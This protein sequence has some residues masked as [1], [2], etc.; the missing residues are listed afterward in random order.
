MRSGSRAIE[1]CVPGMRS[2]H[3]VRCGLSGK[4]QT[5]K[6]IVGLLTLLA[7]SLPAVADA[8]AT[9]MSVLGKAALEKLVQAHGSVE[10]IPT[11]ELW[12]AETYGD[13][14]P[15]RATVSFRSADKSYQLLVWRQ[16]E[17]LIYSIT[18]ND[19][20]SEPRLVCIGEIGDKEDLRS[21]ERFS[22]IVTAVKKD[23]NKDPFVVVLRSGNFAK[24]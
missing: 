5:M 20:G 24:Q 6:W 2:H 4:A 15:D 22:P 8:P 19:K 7:V 18:Q 21:E 16:K 14:L 10:K 13:Y 1:L 23:W 3:T 17:R 12:A 11:G 9:K